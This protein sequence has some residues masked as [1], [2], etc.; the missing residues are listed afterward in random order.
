MNFSK[1]IE[2]QNVTILEIASIKLRVG[3]N[4]LTTKKRLKRY[5]VYHKHID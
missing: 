3:L 4:N 1:L 5:F 2:T